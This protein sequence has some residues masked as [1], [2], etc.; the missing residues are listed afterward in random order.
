MYGEH[1][2]PATLGLQQE[3]ELTVTER[4]FAAVEPF[5]VPHS[6]TGAKRNELSY[7]EALKP[8]FIE[9]TKAGINR[10]IKEMTAKRFDM[11]RGEPTKEEK[12]SALQ[13]GPVLTVKNESELD[14]SVKARLV[15]KDFKNRRLS[16]CPIAL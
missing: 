7:K 16:H 3:V 9:R 11:K 5:L 12:A 15:A 13:A 2:P 8:Q 6:G 4:S 10:E 1:L 14:W